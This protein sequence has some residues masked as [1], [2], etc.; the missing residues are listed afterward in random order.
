M[1]EPL[2]DAVRA[3]IVTPQTLDTVPED[4]RVVL[5]LDAAPLDVA[6]Q[7]VEVVPISTA[8][9]AP[10]IGRGPS[11]TIRHV[12][13]VA[14][15]CQSDT[16][17][18]A[19][20]TRNAITTDLVRRVVETDWENAVELPDDQYVTRASWALEYPDLDPGSIAA[21]STLTITLDTE[22]SL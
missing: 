19:A 20:A 5:D 15:G 13:T 3:L 8:P 9:I 11:L 4:R 2:V 10:E 22:W 1:I 6:L 12:V 14:V 17:A 7:A 21:W 16:I 18:H